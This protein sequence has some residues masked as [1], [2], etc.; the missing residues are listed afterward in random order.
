MEDRDLIV[1]GRPEGDLSKEVTAALWD[2]YRGGKLAQC[3]HDASPLALSVDSSSAY[4]FVC[5][6]CGTASPWFEAGVNGIHLRSSAPPPNPD[7]E[8]A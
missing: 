1:H 3:P 8:E 4:R 7:Y 5:T 6:R 2:K